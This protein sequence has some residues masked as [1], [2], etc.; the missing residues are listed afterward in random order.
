MGVGAQS[1][2]EVCGDR[3]RGA[4]H[5]VCAPGH[6][7][8]KPCVESILGARR[9]W[10]AQRLEPPTVAKIRD[11]R[12]A[13]RAQRQSD[14]VRRVGRPAREDAIDRLAPHQPRQRRER[15]RRPAHEVAVGRHDLREERRGRR[16]R[17]RRAGLGQRRPPQQPAERT[18]VAQ[19]ARADHAAGIIGQRSV[20]RA[21]DHRHLVAERVEVAR[22]A[23]PAVRSDRRGGRVVVG[24]DRDASRRGGHAA[25]GRP[26]NARSQSSTL[27]VR[28]RPSGSRQAPARTSA[29]TAAAS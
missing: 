20:D 10:W 14:D 15:A 8:L 21:G 19:V 2:A 22:H 16:L 12:R 6:A 5:H 17:R 18:C 13:A 3:R 25:A 28:Q 27:S 11:P 29:S 7:R 4:D 23:R 1:R 9:P 26:A 24:D